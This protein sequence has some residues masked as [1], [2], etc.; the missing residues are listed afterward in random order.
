MFNRK[1]LIIPLALSIGNFLLISS[2]RNPRTTYSYLGHDFP[3]TLP[4]GHFG[5]ALGFVTHT[6]EESSRYRLLGWASDNEWSALG[7]SSWGYVRL[8][9]DS[10]IFVISMFHELHCL[11]LLNLAFDPSN[12]VGD[13]HISHC[14]NYLRQ[15]ILC[16]PDLTLEPAD[17]KN[18]N[19]DRDRLGATH[20]CRNWEV[21]YNT[22]E[23]NFGIWNSTRQM[24]PFL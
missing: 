1:Y 12:I 8:G 14:L 18:R 11:R 23:E 9:T 13:G 7:G 16:Q 5:E 21:V 4:L 17:W 2:L 6:I 10:R 22:M 19:F 15:K 24:P 20:V 3:K